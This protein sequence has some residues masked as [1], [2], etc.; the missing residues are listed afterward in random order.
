M[1]ND[2]ILSQLCGR[3]PLLGTFK[4]IIGEAAEMIINCYSSGGKLLV[5]G[6]GGSC[7]DSEHIVGE[8]MKSFE[9]SRPLKK[10]I[11]EKL[12]E[13]YGERG[14]YLAQ[15]LE[16]GLP[17]ISL[18]SQ[19]ALTTAICNDI[20]ANLVFAQQVIGYGRDK[21]VLIAISTSGNSQNVVDACITAK[22]MNLKM[23]GL[24]GMT[25]GKM[26]QYCDILVNVP[27]KRTAYVQELHLPVLHALC[28]LI[29]NHF[30]GNHK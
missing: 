23:I 22:A 25:G 26:K 14:K 5:C 28:L 8:L 16:S 3:H 12:S 20:D 30:Y 24:T 6:N 2:S 13:A 10:E 15:K 7:S 18:S 4:N 27:E 17:A 19:T 11:V 21:D 1:S 29:E 9:L